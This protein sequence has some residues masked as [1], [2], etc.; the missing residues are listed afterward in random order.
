MSSA[1]EHIIRL[2]ET[3]YPSQPGLDTAIARATLIRGSD[4][5]VPETFRLH[6]PGRILAFGKQDVIAPGYAEAVAAARS[7]GF[8][9][10]ERLA[11]G[12]AAAFH[13]G[14]LAFSWMVPDPDPRSHIK[15]RY[16]N[17]SR[18]MVAAF[19]RLGISAAVGQ[20]EGEYCPGEYSVH[21]QGRKVMGV[22]QRLARRAV[23][24]GGVISVT[25]G[26]LLRRVLVPVYE[27][28]DLP[29]NP[30][31]AGALADTVPGLTLAE[32][33]DAVFGE[34]AS[35]GGAVFTDHEPATL[36]LAE[37]LADDHLSPAFELP[38]AD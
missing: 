9:P 3:G 38:H 30:A 18:L 27:A 23:H 37:T 29:W 13:E 12:R 5:E 25:N 8:T 11:G 24:V 14:T 6:V 1:S 10:V 28:L 36:A 33:T 16:L 17:L 35:R 19:D 22:G 32:T 4:G 20:V 2:I 7:M 31:T 34:V 21:V 26:A 15:D